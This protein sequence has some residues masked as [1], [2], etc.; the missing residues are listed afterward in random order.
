[1]LGDAEIQISG[2]D[3][4][5]YVIVGGGSA[6]CVLANRLSADPSVRVALIEAGGLDDWHWI[7]IPAGTRKV[8]GNPRTDW[9]FESEMEPILGRKG[10]VFRGKVLG[11]SSSINGTVYTR[12]AATDYD[13]WRGLGLTGWGWDD[14]L[15]YFRRSERFVDGGGDMHGGEGELHVEHP[16]ISM[17]IFDILTRAAVQAG[18]PYRSDFNGGVIEGCGMFDVTQ[19]RGRRWSTAK[20]FLDP[21]RHRRNLDIVIKTTCTGLVFNG[22]RV[23][24]VDGVSEGRR[25]RIQARREVVLSSGSIG[26]PHLLQLSGIGPGDVLQQAGIT[27]RHENSAVGAN[28]QDHLSIRY[29]A[30][31]HGV[32]TIN[33]RYHSLRKRALMVAE[34]ALFRRGPLVMGAPLWGGFARSD[35]TQVRPNLQFLAMPVSM[36]QSFATPDNFDAVSCGIYNMHPRSRG[37]VRITSPDPKAKPAILHRY[38]T[39]PNDQKV[40]VDS[41]KLL[42]GL[43]SSPAFQALTPEEF[44]P[45]VEMQSDEELLAAAIKAAGTAFHQV[46]TCAM[47]CEK[48]SVVDE[49]LRVR[50][51]SGLRIADGSVLPTLISGN[52]NACIIMIGEKA[53]QMICDEANE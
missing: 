31:V 37:H 49:R 21:V 32:D 39:D 24:G 33:T 15:P 10:L 17:E 50:G 3:T 29:A 22:K 44:T 6:G 51:V 5:D 42:R 40:A 12:G 43:F 1:M 53:A 20:A 8:V 28:L 36:S 7:H 52:T 2:E 47:G 19:H 26:T 4:Y 48:N 9:G 34:Y 18:L 46:G 25:R 14:V 13:H 23:I 27:V 38:L 41:L 45:G 30:K 11:G 16:R 35:Q